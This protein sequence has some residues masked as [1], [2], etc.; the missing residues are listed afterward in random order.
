MPGLEGQSTVNLVLLESRGLKKDNGTLT[1]YC[2]PLQKYHSSKK[3]GASI[4]LCKYA[5]I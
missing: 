2:P 1:L 5:H 4:Q 3:D